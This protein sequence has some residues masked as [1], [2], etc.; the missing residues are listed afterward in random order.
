MS[1]WATAA[2]ELRSDDRA[3]GLLVGPGVV[4]SGDATIGANVVLYRGTIVE[5]GAQIQDHATVGRPS[6]RGNFRS[7]ADAATVVGP[8]AIVGSNAIVSRGARLGESA[9]IA[10]H[11]TVR[12]GT[13]FA[14]GSL[15]GSYA[16]VSQGVSVG[17]NASVQNNSIISPRTVIED[18]VFVGPSVVI[19][20][21][22]S[23]DRNDG[24]PLPFARLRRACRVAGN[25]Q[26]NPGLE[27]GEEAFVGAASL[28]T[29]DVEPRAKMLGVPAR[30][31]GEVTEDELLE[32][33]R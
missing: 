8:G 1:E 5:P 23:L 16:L 30:K 28:V 11:A 25:V 2:G 27:I 10:D 33:W 31:I 22:N 12:D 13:S 15:L 3:P 21:D 18:D 9:F 29:R 26:I 19:V 14:P 20:N 17:R 32:R 7:A 6:V 24:M 4:I